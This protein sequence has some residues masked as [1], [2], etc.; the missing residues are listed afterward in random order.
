V[1]GTALV[2]EEKKSSKQKKKKKG[3]RSASQTGVLD[4]QGIDNR[5]ASQSLQAGTAHADS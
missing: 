3:T 2:P 4:S 5:P 1:S